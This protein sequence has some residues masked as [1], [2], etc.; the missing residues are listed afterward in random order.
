MARS[1]IYISGP[2]TKGDQ[3]HNFR[4]ADEANKE[5]IEAGFAPLNPMFSMKSAFAN[6]IAHHEWLDVDFAFIDCCEAVVRLPGES[7]GADAECD[8]ARSIGVP[9]FEGVSNLAE[10]M[11]LLL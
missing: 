9:V 6:T 1:R 10:R 11:K 2:I 7:A 8:Y 4:Q 3:D 5:L